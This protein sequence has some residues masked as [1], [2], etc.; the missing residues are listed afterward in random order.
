MGKK[1][2]S[3]VVV[4]GHE[5]APM[6][7]HLKAC[8]LINEDMNKPFI[9]IANTF[10]EMHPGHRH[11]RELAQFAKDGVCMSG[12]VPFEFNTISLCDGITQGHEGM[13]FV[14]A[15]RE[16]IVD[17]I[18]VVTQ[19]QQLDGLVLIASCDKIV[20]AVLMAVGRLNIPCVVV[21]GGPM[22]PGKYNNAD[23][24]I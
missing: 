15:S 4:N 2:R 5:G 3:G 7:A 9:G 23:H 20:P 10:N 1:Y 16:L 8:G 13:C 6:R 12:G 19:G 18:E 17:S 22:L 14:L 21:T 24:A 11:L